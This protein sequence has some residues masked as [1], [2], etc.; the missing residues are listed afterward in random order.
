[1]KPIIVIASLAGL[2]CGIV[3][4]KTQAPPSAPDDHTPLAENA[5]APRQT[6]DG[7]SDALVSL[8]WDLRGN[9][10]GDE[11]LA[12]PHGG[13]L[14]AEMNLWSF[15]A[16]PAEL[17]AHWDKVIAS[18]ETDMN[19]LDQLMSLW[20]RRDPKGALAHCRGGDQEYRCFWALARVDPQM[21]LDAVDP[22]DS[23]LLSSVL[24]AIGQNDPDYAKSLLEK[25]PDHNSYTVVQGISDGLA[26]TDPAAAVAYSA[27]QEHFETDRLR[28]WLA[29]DPQAAFA[30]SIENP[31]LASSTLGELVPLLMESDP[32]YFASQIASLPTGKMKLDL[33]KAQAKYLADQ[34]PRQAFALADSQ[35]GPPRR[36][37]MEAMGES[38]V[39]EHPDLAHDLLGKLLKE[40]DSSQMRA[41]TV[42]L[43]WVGNLIER[44]PLAVLAA[45]RDPDSASGNETLGMAERQVFSK[46]TSQDAGRSEDFVRGQAPGARRDILLDLYLDS[47]YHE[48][49]LDYNH[50]IDLSENFAGEL[51]KSY[52]TRRLLQ[53]WNGRSP[54]GLKAFLESSRATPAQREIYETQINRQ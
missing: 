46:W 18:G 52:T 50:L 31:S 32:G 53:S 24:R 13:R 7:N 3:T 26:D 36:A 17:A 25:Y 30:W 38:L 29:K 5:R 34:D 9:L 4:R 16:T 42:S 6:V 11:L 19:T 22:K 23:R 44:D 35:E 20:V 8:S 54:D 1:M 43:D 49:N 27:L 14:L 40:N 10:T 12:L 51:S 45:T 28:W 15:K 2:A 37:L 41:R 39:G 48:K 47:R 21:A 33:L